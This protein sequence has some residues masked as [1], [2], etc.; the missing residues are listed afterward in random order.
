VQTNPRVV[1]CS[2]VQSLSIVGDLIHELKSLINSSDH[3]NADA[4]YLRPRLPIVLTSQLDTRVLLSQLD[5]TDTTDRVV[6]INFLNLNGID[7]HSLPLR[8]DAAEKS[9]L[10]QVTINLDASMVALFYDS[11]PLGLRDMFP[12][13]MFKSYSKYHPEPVCPYVFTNAALDYLEIGNQVDSFL[14]RNLWYFAR[15]SPTEASIH[16]NILSFKA[17]GFRLRLDD[18]LASPLVFESTQVAF[19]N[20]SFRSIQTDLFKSFTSLRVFYFVVSDLGNFFHEIG[21]EWIPHCANF[22]FVQFTDYDNSWYEYSYPDRDFCVFASFPFERFITPVLDTNLAECTHTIQWL[23]QIYKDAYAFNPHMFP[24]NTIQL[25]DICTRIEFDRAVFDKKVQLCKINQTLGNYEVYP[26]FFTIEST[27]VLVTACV[28]YLLIPVGSITGFILN[29]RV[30]QTIKKNE[31]KEL[32]ETFYQY[33]SLNSKFNCVFCL[34]YV[35]YPLTSCSES[36]DPNLFFCTSISNSY[37]VQYYKIICVNFIG[38]TVKMSANF[39]YLLMTIN[40]YMLIGR[41]HLSI[42]ERISKLELKNVV[43]FTVT[44]SSLVN[45]GHLFQYQIYDGGIEARR[46]GS[47]FWSFNYPLTASDYQRFFTPY[48]LTYFC[49]DFGLFFFINTAI[50]ISIL[51]KFHAEL[52][53]KQRKM[54]EMQQANQN[55]INKLESDKKKEQRAITM[56]ALNSLVNFILRCPEVFIISKNLDLLSADSSVTRFMSKFQSIGLLLYNISYF[57]YILTFSTNVLIYFK[58]N[59]AFNKAFR[60]RS[61]TNTNKKS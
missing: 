4:L 5:L 34:A 52:K 40:R 6:A 12:G 59:E 22:S 10:G 14:V 8:N 33:M 19:F 31:K 42:L 15:T 26:G 13:Y 3:P 9:A 45:V 57:L 29:R 7:L 58:F 55:Q 44:F 38:E 36:K 18:S 30:V 39:S 23:M 41:E 20:G 50:E 2:P 54:Q 53:E 35:L 56:V 21:I 46:D 32:K 60:F 37:I 24:E 11:T 17:Q 49:V 28:I 43:I 61:N 51:R 1:D 48:S 16:A 47:L 25:Y 27:L